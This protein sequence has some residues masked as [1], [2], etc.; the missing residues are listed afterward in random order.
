MVS[1]C[2]ARGTYSAVQRR[3]AG[4]RRR[5]A[6]KTSALLPPAELGH[7][8][9]HVHPSVQQVSWQREGRRSA[10]PKVLRQG[11]GCLR[12]RP[13]PRVRPE[14]GSWQLPYRRAPARPPLTLD[15]VLDGRRVPEVAL[16]VLRGHRGG[17]VGGGVQALEPHAQVG[18]GGVRAEQAAGA[19][20]G[21][22]VNGGCGHHCGSALWSRF[23]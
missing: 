13:G 12:A 14:Y 21:L 2:I 8:S 22:P 17:R 7:P 9:R 15:K 10:A 16:H 18:L 20:Q 19:S 1:R 11:Q 3:A 4:Q 5:T 6:T 23:W